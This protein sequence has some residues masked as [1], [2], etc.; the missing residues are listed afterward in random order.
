MA[1]MSGDKVV[2]I[3]S[4]HFLLASEGCKVTVGDSAADRMPELLDVYPNGQYI[5]EMAHDRMLMLCVKLCL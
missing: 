3:A 2:C 5:S 4:E 1:L